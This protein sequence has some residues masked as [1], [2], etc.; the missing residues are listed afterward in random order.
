[1]LVSNVLKTA[2]LML[3]LEEEFAP[4]FVSSAVSAETQKKFNKL[5]DSFNLCLSEISTDYIPLL[6]SQTL[7]PVGGKLYSNSTDMKRIYEIRTKSGKKLKYK[8]FEGF[9]SIDFAGPVEVTSFVAPQILTL[10]STFSSFGGKV[11]EKCLAMGTSAEYCFLAA[12]YNDAEIW[13]NRFRQALNRACSKKD[14]LILPERRW[15]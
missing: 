6:T 11:S 9:V 5:L 3:G 1:M 4:I 10:N 12:L 7:T 13:D 2:S 8:L 15:L 14:S